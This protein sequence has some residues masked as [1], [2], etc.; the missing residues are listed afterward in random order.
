MNQ[1][2]RI[3]RSSIVVAACLLFVPAPGAQ[4]WSQDEVRSDS[5]AASGLGIRQRRYV[6]DRLKLIEIRIASLAVEL[7]EGEPER[8]KKLTSALERMSQMTLQERA[9]TIAAMLDKRELEHAT[10]QQQT[11]LKD[12]TELLDLLADD[13]SETDRLA[14][15]VRE[16]REWKQRLLALRDDEA[17]QL[18]T[19]DQ[20]A[21]PEESLEQ[22]ELQIAEV[23]RLI[24]QQQQLINDNQ[25]VRGTDLDGLDQIAQLQEALRA[26]TEKLAEQIDSAPL[27]RAKQ[28]DKRPPT[29]GPSGN[30][31]GD[32]QPGDKEPDDEQP[33]DK[34]KPPGLRPKNPDDKL[35]DE[36]PDAGGPKPTGSRS[37]RQQRRNRAGSQALRKSASHQ[38][39]ARN[40]LQAKRGKA[41]EQDQK[42]SL[43]ELRRA[44]DELKDT[45]RRLAR[46]KRDVSNDLADRQDQTAGETQDLS[47]QIQQSSQ[48]SQQA[49]QSQ[50]QPGQPKPGQPSKPQADQRLQEAIKK[51]QQDMQNATQDLQRQKPDEAGQDQ[52]QALEN[53]DKGIDEI[54]KQLE[55][56]QDELNRQRLASLMQ[57]YQ[58]M[59]VRQ[60]DATKA[61]ALV[62]QR[63]GDQGRLR[64]ADAIMV[65][66]LGDEER[67]LAQLAQE[68]ADEIMEDG[69]ST[70]LPQVAIRLH[71]DLVRV[72]DRLD[73]R[74]TNQDTKTVQLEIEWT[75]EELI[76][77]LQQAQ[78]SN[79]QKSQG[80][81][82]QGQGQGQ[83]SGDQKLIPDKAELKLL[84]AA[85]RRINRLTG[86]F[87]QQRGEKALD[88]LRRRELR[89]IAE[90]QAEVTRMTKALTVQ[91]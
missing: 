2:I 23:E 45:K 51:A 70:I 12:L 43:A 37:A 34:P 28:D 4:V 48:D 78:R 60:R 83:Q 88:E 27:H 79:E 72:A 42:R 35:D 32:K 50:P 13:D 62:E 76:E 19:S 90:R 9:V 24:Q 66:R 64:R 22:V 55:D 41:G 18:E 58:E 86:A 52:Q 36:P 29:D 38:S 3:R 53:L 85:Q 20:L 91:E 77:A 14:E 71:D 75:L 6:A 73:Q 46:L 10:E 57:R 63:R 47:D 89:I 33:P 49:N 31:P 8:A 21:H 82:G 26:A 5:E 7:Q 1:S 69:S 59:L 30:K 15:K 39:A 65:R 56:V 61:T 16:L 81:A 80:G 11:V 54:E 44:Q 25:K 68:A 74:S 87:D 67:A 17:D 40:K 84:R